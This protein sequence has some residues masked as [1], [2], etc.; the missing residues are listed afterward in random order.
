MRLWAIVA[1]ALSCP[2]AM[3][4]DAAEEGRKLAAALTQADVDTLGACQARVEGTARLVD[5]FE[6]WLQ[7]EGHTAQLASIRKAR[8]NGGE[9]LARLEELR[10]RLGGEAVEFDL[11]SSEAARTAMAATFERRP[12]ESDANAYTRWQAATILGQDCRDAMKRALAGRARCA[13]S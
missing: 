11:A 3:A 5:T 13:G 9:L 2:A 7:Q 12:G 8:D 4:Q 6:V 1:I 10:T